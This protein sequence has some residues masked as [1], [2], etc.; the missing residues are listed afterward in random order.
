MKQVYENNSRVSRWRSFH[1]LFRS[2]MFQKHL[3][4]SRNER[5]S[6]RAYDSVNS[7]RFHRDGTHTGNL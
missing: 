2:S 1:S 5:R 3:G 4:G 6:L 7:C